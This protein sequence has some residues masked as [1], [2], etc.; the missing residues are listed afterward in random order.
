MNKVLVTGGAGFIGSNFVH[1]M[2]RCYR[3]LTMVNLDSLTYAGNLG[4]L[5]DLKE[6]S[7]HIFIRGSVGDSDLL[8]ELFS[9]HA[10]D[11]VVNFAAETHVDRSLRDAR[12]FLD[13]NLGGTQNLLDA[14]R[15]GGAGRFVQIS[16]D[17]VYGSLGEQGRFTEH[18]PITPNNPYSA[19]KAGAD[20][21]ALAAHESHD[22]DVVITRCSNNYGP[23]QFPEK[24]IP[25]MIGNALD[26][27][28]LPVYGDG[29][30]VRDWIHV[31]DHCAAIDTVLRTG[32]A[33][34]IYN[35]G[36]MHDV[37][38]VE[39]VKEIL[40]HLGKPE[41]L[42]QYVEDRPGHDRRYA[43]D[44][45]KI[46]N[47]LGWSPTVSFRDGLKATVEWYVNSKDW[48]DEIRSG[49]YQVYYQKM[50]GDRDR[51]TGIRPV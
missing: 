47:E 36:S 41:S 46:Q 13:T 16:T 44:A 27:K 32:R 8:T 30:H 24:L 38:N 2:L 12:P 23:F 34:E 31:D 49:D 33:G 7:R 39:V 42:I 9:E 35:V 43:I 28:R 22:L 3:D 15:A 4:N 45:S 50:Y 19:T 25:L 20:F 14:A 11:A 6:D 26:D 1:H 5:S 17:E 37:P 10:F 51:S 18:S 21:L 29:L 40:H 48:L